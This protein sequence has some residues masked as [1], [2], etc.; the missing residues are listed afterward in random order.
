MNTK[1]QSYLL[2]LLV[3]LELLF[4]L[5]GEPRFIFSDDDFF[6]PL[7]KPLAPLAFPHTLRAAWQTQSVRKK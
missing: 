5:L 2:T 7:Y 3:L 1:K 4:L 6:Q